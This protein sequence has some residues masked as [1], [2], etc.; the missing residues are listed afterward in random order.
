MMMFRLENDSP[1][2]GRKL[3]YLIL[4]SV[5]DTTIRLENDSP[6]RGRKQVTVYTHPEMSSIV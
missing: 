2:R 1:S 5:D 3:Y 4:K 6:S